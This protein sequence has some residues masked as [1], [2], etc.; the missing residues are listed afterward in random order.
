[1]VVGNNKLRTIQNAGELLAILIAMR[2]RR[3]DAGRIAQWSRSMAL[4]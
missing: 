3:Y 4:L 2:M 1:M